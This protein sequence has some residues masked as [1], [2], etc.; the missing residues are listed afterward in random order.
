MRRNRRGARSELSRRRFL[1]GVGGTTLA[2]PALS[3]FQNSAFAQSAAVPKRLIIM[4][5]P[6][7][8]LREEWVGNSDE[9]NFTLGPVLQ[10][11]ADFRDDLLIL[12][13]LDSDVAHS[14]GPGDG[15]QTGMGCMLTGRKLL[16]GSVKGG[17]GGCPPAGLASGIS[18]DQHIANALGAGSAFRSLELGVQT[19]NNINAW[20][21]MSYAGRDDAMSPVNDP[22]VVWD[23]LAGR[24]EQEQ[25]DSQ[26]LR[27]I[28][29]KRRST[30]AA[31][32]SDLAALREYAPSDDREK[33]DRHVEF[34]NRLENNIEQIGASCSL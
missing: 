33:L 26:E 8:T 29:A 19:P 1:R 24:V 21:R 12:R 4:F 9:F 20:T 14:G 10:P 18:I 7:G 27:R 13:G 6:N 30:Y 2:L 23:R 3:M 11:L 32:K 34:V 28:S 16:E 15:H 5:S 17:C 22:E 25:M 31:V